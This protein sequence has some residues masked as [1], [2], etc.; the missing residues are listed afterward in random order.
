MR[1]EG[2]ATPWYAAW[3]PSLGVTSHQGTRHTHRQKAT[4]NNKH[5]AHI[6]SC[7]GQRDSTE[8]GMKGTRDGGD[9]GWS[10]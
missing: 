10:G 1:S 4:S 9:K 7:W 3:V 5:S 2:L 6:I 8:S